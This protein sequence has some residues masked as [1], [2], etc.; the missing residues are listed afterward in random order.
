MIFVQ[1]RFDIFYIFKTVNLE[2]WL[3]HPNG[4]VTLVT[5]GRENCDQT[6]VRSVTSVCAWQHSQ[7][8][9]PGGN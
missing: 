3:L 8:F 5:D 4:A 7:T 1:L 9:Y 6:A 2:Y